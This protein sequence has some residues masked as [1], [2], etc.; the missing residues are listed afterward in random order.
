M[1]DIVCNISG[2]GIWAFISQIKSNETPNLYLFGENA[3][4]MLQMNM[5]N[6]SSSVN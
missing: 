5:N 4:Y 1:F 6:T 3:Y 2:C